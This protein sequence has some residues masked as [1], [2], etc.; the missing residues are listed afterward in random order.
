MALRSDFTQDTKR[1]G[2]VVPKVYAVA[3]LVVSARRK[4]RCKRKRVSV[5][6]FVEFLESN[7]KEKSNGRVE[8]CAILY[9]VTVMR[10]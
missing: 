7:G 2:M 5:Y 9:E 4:A 6:A 1:S 3:T 8:I 10:E